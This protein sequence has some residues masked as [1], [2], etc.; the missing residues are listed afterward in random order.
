MTEPYKYTFE[1]LETLK[2]AFASGV[3]RVTFGDKTT[4]YRTLEEIRKAISFV[5]YELSIRKMGPY[6]VKIGVTK[7]E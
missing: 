5:E 2:R 1:D 4:E 3:L 7:P 6:F